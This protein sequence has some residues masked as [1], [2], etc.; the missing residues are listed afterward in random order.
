MPERSA[1]LPNAVV[2]CPNFSLPPD[3]NLPS[4]RADFSNCS[5]A[6]LM[7][8]AW[9]AFTS[10]ASAASGSSPGPSWACLVLSWADVLTGPQISSY[11]ADSSAWR[12]ST[13]QE[14]PSRTFPVMVKYRLLEY[15]SMAA[16][17]L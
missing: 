2:T 4:L 9:M 16:S 17:G 3:T 15:I 13:L 12:S 7:G 14:Y 11:R 8:Q 5:L 1:A 6:P 10:A